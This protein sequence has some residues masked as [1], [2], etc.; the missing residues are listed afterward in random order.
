M[1]HAIVLTIKL[2]LFITMVVAVF[3][4]DFIAALFWLLLNKSFFKIEFSKLKEA[5]N[6]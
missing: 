6:E 5:P 4:K 1:I 2:C 3:H